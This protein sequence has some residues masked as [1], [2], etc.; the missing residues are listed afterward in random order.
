MEA[1]QANM[2]FYPFF[3][4][5]CGGGGLFDAGWNHLTGFDSNFDIGSLISQN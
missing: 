3:F 4:E 5:G 2:K 1:K